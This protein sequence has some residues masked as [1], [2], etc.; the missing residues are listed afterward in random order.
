MS[1]SSVLVPLVL[2]QGLPRD[3][4]AIL[5][6]AGHDCVHAGEIGMAK[7]EDREIIAWAR[8]HRRTVVTLDADFHSELAASGALSPSVIRLRLQGMDA[9]A[10]ARL[11]Q[12]IVRKY[13]GAL[14][15]GCVISVTPKKIRLRWL[16]V[17]SD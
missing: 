10:V 16:P 4:A 3:A 11:V 13:G 17:G 8:Q 6:Q 1:P 14:I 2:D 12:T 5:R 9:P 7:A 15:R